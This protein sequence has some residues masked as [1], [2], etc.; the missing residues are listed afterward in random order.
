MTHLEMVRKLCSLAPKTL[1]EEILASVMA[2]QE[3]LEKNFF[4]GI[5]DLTRVEILYDKYVNGGFE[6]ACLDD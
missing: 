2:T 5:P 3:R 4:V 6:G 1:P